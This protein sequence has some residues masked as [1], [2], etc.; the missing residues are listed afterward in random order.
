M[1]LTKLCH[2][3]LSVGPPVYIPLCGRPEALA[4]LE[5]GEGLGAAVHPL[6]DR[7][8]GGQWE[9]ALG[10]LQGCK[11]TWTFRRKFKW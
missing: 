10:I 11:S 2:L 6:V 3:Y 9:G 1:G 8:G 5:A 4:A 7:L